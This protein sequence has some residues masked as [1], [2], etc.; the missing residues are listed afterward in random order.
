MRRTSSNFAAAPLVLMLVAGCFLAAPA[1]GGNVLYG[2]L[3]VEDDNSGGLKPINYLV[4]LYS[5]N[6]YVQSRQTVAPN[7]RYRFI[8][9]VDGD[10]DVVVEVENV[11]VARLRIQLRSP[12]YN[13]DFKHDITLA[14]K[15]IHNQPARPASVSLEDFYKRAPE[16]QR[17][18]TRAREA[19]DKKKYGEGVHLLKQLVA[20]DANDFQAWTELGT[21]FLM[22]KNFAEAESAY[23]HSIQVRPKFYLAL[24]NLGRLRMMQRRFE[25]AIPPFSRALEVKATSADANYFLGEAYLQIKKGSKAVGYFYQALKLDPIGKAEAHLRLARLYNG[26]GLKQKAAVEY[27][28]FLKKKPDYPDRKKLAEYIAQNK[29]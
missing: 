14:W 6:G 7:G 5:A 9:L 16:N 13:N 18:F 23:E 4:I 21:A 24:M 20:S 22:D 1:Q 12:I 26:A 17:V 11:E 8:N 3:I 10:Y 2:D 25:E 15:G 19:I 28:E 27:A 29:K